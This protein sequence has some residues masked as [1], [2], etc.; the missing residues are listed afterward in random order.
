MHGGVR[1]KEV[2]V[3]GLGQEGT[4]MPRDVQR[5]VYLNATLQRRMMVMASYLYTCHL[6]V[7][8]APARA[9]KLSNKRVAHVTLRG[10]GTAGSTVP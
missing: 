4:S 7:H 1:R 8:K 3:L 9:P 6:A 10:V 2:H 5:L